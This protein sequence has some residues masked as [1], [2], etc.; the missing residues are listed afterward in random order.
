MSQ[1]LPNNQLINHEASLVQVPGI[2]DLGPGFQLS[3][4][5]EFINGF[6]VPVTMV[7]RTGMPLIIQPMNVRALT[8][9]VVRYTIK[10]RV[11]V[12]IDVE[13]LSNATT[14]GMRALRDAVLSGSVRQR[15]GQCFAQVDYGV[16]EDEVQRNGGSLYLVNLDVVVSTMT[17][18]Y[19][20][21][22]PFSVDGIR[23][24]LVASNDTINFAGSV[25]YGLQIVD[26][27]EV[28]GPRYIN[29]N[30]EIYLV[31]PAKDPGRLSGVY[32]ASTGPVNESGAVGKPRADYY[33]FPE[34]EAMLGMFRSYE[35][36]VVM[37]DIAAEKKRELDALALE[38][39]TQEHRNKLERLQR[40]EEFETWKRDLEQ[41][42]AAEE[43]DRKA[44]E[45][46]WKLEEARIN[47]QAARLK[48]E[49]TRVEHLRGIAALERKDHYE[50]RSYVRKDSSELLKWVPAIA[51]SVAALFLAFK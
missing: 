7:D 19:V 13:R 26:N 37:G 4:E 14:E 48:E 39:K 15:M 36:A 11:G 18:G 35:E 10:Y 29:I 8:K 50:E 24:R 38:L 1:Y 27:E 9:F 46:R 12:N 28:F 49:Q 20:P 3:I 6:K 17:G 43:S 42:R 51:A 21:H 44:Q 22:H 40:E 45:H 25:G 30:K 32:R 47:E 41:R 34:A 23:N 16:D 33:A 31:Q 5:K 2:L